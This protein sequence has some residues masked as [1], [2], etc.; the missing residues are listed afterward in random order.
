MTNKITRRQALKGIAGVA[1]VLA[2]PKVVEAYENQPSLEESLARLPEY[3]KDTD[4]RHLENEGIIK[5]PTKNLARIFETAIIREMT[6]SEMHY[7]GSINGKSQYITK[8]PGEVEVIC[9]VIGKENDSVVISREAE[10]GREFVDTNTFRD[11]IGYIPI[12]RI[13]GYRRL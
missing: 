5:N 6:R 7:A 9:Y 8:E 10:V 4:I 11:S 12:E 2:V 1:G 13:K 3:K